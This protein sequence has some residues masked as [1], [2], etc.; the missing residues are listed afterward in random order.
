MTQ[1]GR[2][3][4]ATVDEIEHLLGQLAGVLS[5]RIV[6]N[7]WG[8]IEEIHILASTERAPKQVVRDVESTL[9]ARW[10]MNVDH[11]KISVA[12][13][14]GSSLPVL[15][16]RVKLL[17]VKLAMDGRLGKA[18]A[19]VTLGRAD[20][21]AVIYEGK[22]QGNGSRA[23][24]LRVV[25]EA[26]LSA[27]N[28]ALEPSSAFVLEEAATVDLSHRELV[29]VTLVLVSPRRNEEVLVGAV[30]VKGEL[31]K[32]VVKAVLD[33]ANRRLAKL[34]ARRSRRDAAS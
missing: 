20:D 21:D 26:T 25:A 8:A 13:V 32:A 15:P 9:A 4:G 33:A 6:V 28:Q 34:A 5:A 1:E 3:T 18:E 14:T 2:R 24:M 11:K 29:V 7:D 30:A 31:A 12:Q 22:S 19:I 27:L 17:G 23:G 10:G 16:L